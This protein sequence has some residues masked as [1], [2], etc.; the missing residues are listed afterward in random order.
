MDRN[1]F[2]SRQQPA[3]AGFQNRAGGNAYEF[4]D[5]EKLAQYSATGFFGNTYYVDAAEQLTEV[6]SLAERLPSEFVAKC[7]VYGRKHANLKDVPAFLVAMLASRMHEQ[8]GVPMKNSITPWFA[9][10]FARAI[11]NSK[12]LSNFC[13]VIRSGV[14]GRKNFGTAPR[15]MVAQWLNARYPDGLFRDSVG[16]TP[17]LKDIIKM[18]RPKPPDEARRLLYAYLIDKEVKDPNVELLP[19]LIRKFEAFKF[20][21][22]AMEAITG[23]LQVPDVP[24]R[25]LD[26]LQLSDAEWS[27]VARNAPWQMT[28]MNLNTFERHGVFKNAELTEIIAM[29]LID[30]GLIA[31]SRVFPYQML[32]AYQNVSD[33]VPQL[34]KTALEAAADMAIMNVPAFTGKIVACIDVSGSMRSPITGAR[35]GATSKMTYVEAAALMGATVLRRSQNSINFAFDT[36]LYQMKAT[37]APVLKLAQTLAKFGGGGTDCALPLRR[38][39]ETHECGIDAVIFVSDNESWVNNGYWHNRS[40]SSMMIEWAKL[41]THNPQAKLVCIDIAAGSSAQAPSGADRLNIGGFNDRVFDVIH[42]FLTGES[43]SWVAKIEAVE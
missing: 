19:E 31:K 10:A 27:Q 34:I 28:R 25:M 24:F 35:K 5:K 18:T 26:S 22:K 29:R 8:N 23:D 11:D 40:A 2:S 1:L 7:A 42:S 36:G 30:Q 9:W 41:K 20:E 3:A 12:M 6:K 32:A 38:L 15:R 43:S 33:T 17:S 4:S 37:D 21:R 16:I 14:T 13:Q 39:N